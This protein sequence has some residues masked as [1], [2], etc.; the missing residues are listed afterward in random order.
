MCTPRYDAMLAIASSEW[1]DRLQERIWANGGPAGAS[2]YLHWLCTIL[3]TNADSV[4]VD[5][6]DGRVSLEMSDWENTLAVAVNDDQGDFGDGDAA[7]LLAL[8]PLMLAEFQPLAAMV[9][10]SPN[11]AGPGA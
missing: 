10:H 11:T 2:A 9:E 3:H 8:L 4:L 1:V 5:D 6:N 7:T